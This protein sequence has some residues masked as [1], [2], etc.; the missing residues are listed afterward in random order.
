MGDVDNTFVV[1]AGGDPP[2]PSVSGRLPASARVI[3]ADSG[4]GHAMRLGIPVD[5]L[6]GDLDSVDQRDLDAAVAAGVEVEVYPV[7]KDHTDLELALDR[8]RDL[9]ASRIEVVGGSGDRLDHFLANALLFASPAYESVRIRAHMGIGCLDVVRTSISFDGKAGDL[10]S[11]LAVHGVA[12]GVRTAG[13]L[14]PLDGERL[15]GGSTRGVSNEMTGR[16]ASVEVAEG[17]VVAVRPGMRGNHVLARTE[18]PAT[19]TR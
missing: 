1:F 4:L 6:V 8:A 14:Y 9:G 11:L 17:V 15:V 16:M 12:D 3:A 13:L 7:A 2:H 10:V 18:N 19:T 5:V